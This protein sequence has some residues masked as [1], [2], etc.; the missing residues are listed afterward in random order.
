MSQREQLIAWMNDARAMEFSVL[1]VLRRHLKR[2]EGHSNRILH[3]QEHIEETQEHAEEMERCI[4]LLGGTVSMT[5]AF[6]GDL[7]GRAQ[8]ISSATASDEWVKNALIEYATEHF[9][10]GCYRSLIVAAEEMGEEEIAAVCRRILS[11]EEKMARWAEEQ[12][13]LNTRNYLRTQPLVDVG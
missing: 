11:D 4:Q 9:E 10:M 3:L 5:K 12:I 6:L 2:A 13:L 8:G 7:F 1:E